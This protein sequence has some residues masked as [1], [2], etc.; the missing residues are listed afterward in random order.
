MLPAQKPH[1][2]TPASATIKTYGNRLTSF[3]SQYSYLIAF[4]LVF[5]IACLTSDVFFTKTNL[6]NILY[7][8]SIIG[9]IALGMSLVILIGG[10]DLSVGSVLAFCGTMILLTL[11]ATHNIFLAVLAGLGMGAV[12]GLVNGVFITRAKIAPFIMTLG[13]MATFRSL[14]LFLNKGGGIT[15]TVMSYANIANGNL[16]GIAY[17]IY[18]FLVMTALV[19]LVTTKLPYGRHLYAIGSN[20]KAATLSA[21]AVSKIK[22]SV[23]TLC[24]LLVGISAIIESSRLCSVSASS[25]GVSYE[26]DAIAAVIIGGTSMSGGRGTIIGTFFG[27]LILGILNN[28]LN[29]ADVSPYLQGMVKGI[30]IIFAVLIQRKDN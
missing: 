1:N 23:Y 10:I 18:L 8:V 2:V 29:L 26:L 5:L 3:W 22:I 12:I 13:S 19:H 28:I 14:A 7:Q 27:V 21:I 24:G 30:I 9:I 17:P 25:S 6:M 20:E 4:A 16:C 15:G 11:N